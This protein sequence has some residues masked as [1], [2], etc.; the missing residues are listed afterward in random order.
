VSLGVLHA[1]YIQNEY[2]NSDRIRGMQKARRQMK[3][4]E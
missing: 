4:N 2:M 3:G 1:V